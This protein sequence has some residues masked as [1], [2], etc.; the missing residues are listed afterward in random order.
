MTS[1]DLALLDSIRGLAQAI[2]RDAGL[3]AT[4]TE[5]HHDDRVWADVSVEL[6]I[7]KFKSWRGSSKNPISDHQV[8]LSEMRDQMMDWLAENRK[9]SAP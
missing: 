8:S 2:R 7:G 5:H 6:V 1:D 9:R 4:Y 3:Y